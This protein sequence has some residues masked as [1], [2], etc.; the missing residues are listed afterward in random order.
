M[1]QIVHAFYALVFT[2]LGSGGKPIDPIPLVPEFRDFHDRI[3]TGQTTLDV[4]ETK[5]QFGRIHLKQLLQSARTP[6]FQ[7]ALRI[8]AK[9]D[10]EA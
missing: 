1:R 9:S 8:V 7:D 10:A 4:P 6:R 3:W 2:N 5:L